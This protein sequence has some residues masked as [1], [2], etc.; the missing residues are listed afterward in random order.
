MQVNLITGGLGFI[1]SYL[2]RTL[3]SMGEKVV[4]LDISR[5]TSYIQDVQDQTVI[6][7]GDFSEFSVVADIIK[8]HKINTVFHLGAIV[9]PAAEQNIVNTFNI[10]CK[11]TINFLECSRLFGIDKIIY[12]STIGVYGSDSDSKV[13][14]DY[15]QRPSHIY[16]MSKSCSER[17]GE[18]YYSRYGVDFRGL[19]FPAIIGP[20][21]WAFGAGDY[22]DRAIGETLFGKPYEINGEAVTRLPSGVYVQDAADGLIT[23]RDTDN[24]RL[25][26]RVY[27][28]HGLD[29]I[30]GDLVDA[31][32]ANIPD[33]QLSYAP[34]GSRITEE[35]KTWPELIDDN[36]RKDW[37]WSPKITNTSDYVRACIKQGRK[38]P[39]LYQK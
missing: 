31:I 32:K 29:V 4:V 11:S 6:V 38:F 23:L 22:C 34:E 36:A 5:N 27:N 21:R 30:A 16:G 14:D 15:L 33:A 7:N 18:Q 24:S 28:I 2:V 25:K 26:R 1:G 20:G 10:N 39:Q 8:E 13:D 17:I 12:V 37:N 3:L 19:R 9:P 35:F